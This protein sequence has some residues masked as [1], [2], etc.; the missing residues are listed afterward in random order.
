[1]EYSLS[2]DSRGLSEGQAQ[3][4]SI[5]RAL[6]RDAP[7]LLLDEAT[8]AIDIS[9]ERTILRNLSQAGKT[10]IL[11]THRPTALSLCT[12]VY[13]IMDREIRQLSQEQIES[14]AAEF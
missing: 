14:Y 8:S 6:L 13:R 1:M 12:R 5:A 9:T 10:C 2:E 4:L 7:V 11:T 3:R